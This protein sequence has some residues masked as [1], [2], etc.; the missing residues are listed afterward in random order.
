MTVDPDEPSDDRWAAVPPVESP[1]QAQTARPLRVWTV[2][3]VFLA[4]AVACTVVQIPVVI[5]LVSSADAAS[6]DR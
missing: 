5:V 3:A 6:P 1:A 2:F 4:T